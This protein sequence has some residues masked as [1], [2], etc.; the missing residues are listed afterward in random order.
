LRAQGM[1]V[2]TDAFNAAMDEQKAAARAAWSGSGDSVNEKLW[3][4]LLEEVG[5]TEFLGYDKQSAEGKILA[6]LKDDAL[7]DALTEG[8][9]GI[10]ITNQSP[11]YA[12]SGGQVG[13]TGRFVSGEAELNVIDTKKKLGKLWA[14]IVKAEKGTVKKGATVQMHVDQERRAAIQANHSVTHLL[15]E[16]L[17]R[18]LGDHVT[19][20][21]SLQDADRTRFDISHPSAIAQGELQKI[22]DMVNAEIAANTPVETRVMAIDEAR[23]TGAMALFGEKY[24]DEVRVVAMGS[25]GSSPFF[26]GEKEFS[27]EL[28]G[29][30][31]VKSTGEIERFKI[32]SEGALSA[33]V[34]RVEAVTG[35]RVEAYVQG[36]KA[37]LQAE[38]DR[39]M[40]ENTKLRED[41][42]SLGGHSGDAP[43][44]EPQA[45]IKDNKRL[46]KEIADLRRKA[47]TEGSEDDIKDI[48]GIKFV[49]KVLD[50]FPAKDLK[51]MA[52]ELKK[53]I[54]S[55]VVALVAT[56]D[57]K[58]SI[59]VA[60]TD[61]LT[62]NVNA[63]DLVR[64]GSE[65]LGG[66]GG[67]GRPDMAQAGGP[68]AGA[69]NDSVKA[70]EGAL[71]G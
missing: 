58:A 16:A 49:G 28:C 45:I 6:I 67:G 52:D 11:F 64:V 38:I 32:I 57:G 60:V 47:G 35:E 39:L 10:V 36:Q 29:G 51:P 44:A 70:I 4:D 41:L 43:G 46:Q 15:H 13:D 19:Q 12:E 69:A 3:F 63:V 61:D 23:E 62:G 7:V 9:E 2:D 56:N 71:A 25:R 17:R 33:G 31:H 22:E 68:D 21:G 55:G 18:T 5:P 65:A 20:K 53:K 48:A 26:K 54:G 30:T 37:A 14:H 34:R 24:D 27:V 59:V 50:G 8:E 66:K 40:A 1:E 42:T